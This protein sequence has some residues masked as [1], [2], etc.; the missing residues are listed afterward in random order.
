MNIY[1]KFPLRAPYGLLEED[2]L[3]LC[4]FENLAFRLPWQPIT[5]SDFDKTH[6]VGRGLLQ[7]DFCKLSS[8][9]LQ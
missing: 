4:F 2:F 1:A 8:K 5:F 6:M 9:Y 7:E 3:L